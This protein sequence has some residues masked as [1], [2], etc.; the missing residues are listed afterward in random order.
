MLKIK[1]ETYVLIMGCPQDGLPALDYRRE[2][3]LPERMD[4]RYPISCEI[5][6][7][8]TLYRLLV[9]AG[10]RGTSYTDGTEAI[11]AVDRGML[12]FPA[13]SE[14]YHGASYGWRAEV[15]PATLRAEQQ[16]QGSRQWHA[17]LGDV[18]VAIASDSPDAQRARR[19]KAQRAAELRQQIAAA[20][21][22]L[23]AL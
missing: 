9:A 11:L 23:A 3:G 7:D 19:A 17:T 5:A 4:N 20:E 16:A 8:E 15:A 2:H 1:V 22:A 14:T 6:D 12:S 13:A 10:Y 18:L 21:Q